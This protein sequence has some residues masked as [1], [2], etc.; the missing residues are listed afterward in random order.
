MPVAPHRRRTISYSRARWM[1][2]PGMSLEAALRLC[3]ENCPDVDATRLPLRN[4]NAELRHRRLNHGAVY[5]HIA[6]WTEGEPASIVPHDVV[7]D[8]AD[9][10][11][12]APDDTW[13]FLDGD[14]MVLVAD[15]H[16]LLMPSGLHPKA[17]ELYLRNLLQHGREIC[18]AAIP[19]NIGNYSHDLESNSSIRA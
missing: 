11:E 17:L 7:G 14:G 5:L 13:D 15:D 9:L 10:D 1:N 18:R 2:A 16:C 8:E 4:M 3:L 6:A 12:R 19:N